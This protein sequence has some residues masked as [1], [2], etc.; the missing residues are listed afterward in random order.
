[1][2]VARLLSSSPPPFRDAPESLRQFDRPHA[3]QDSEQSSAPEKS[4]QFASRATAASAPPE[5]RASCGRS[6]RR[7]GTELLPKPAPARATAASAPEM[8]LTCLTR[9]LLPARSLP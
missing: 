5:A 8:S 6:V 7:S 9:I 3:L 1:L 4:F 2:P